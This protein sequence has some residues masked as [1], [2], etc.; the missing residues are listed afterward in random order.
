MRQE[1]EVPPPPQ[2]HPGG[3]LS[4][5]K[6]KRFSVFPE[7]LRGFLGSGQCG[8]DSMWTQNGLR[9]KAGSLAVFCRRTQMR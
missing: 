8:D 7:P 6:E 1:Q 9:A 5:N 3:G 4:Q 2:Q